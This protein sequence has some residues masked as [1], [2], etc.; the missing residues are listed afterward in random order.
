MS[1]RFADGVINAGGLCMV[2]V[3]IAAIDERVRAYLAGVL[4]GDPS[5]ELVHASVRAQRFARI[6]M[7]TADA[8]GS[9]PMALAFI[10]LASVL[11]GTFMLR[12]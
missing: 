9:E 12:G 8:H 10:A 2:V 1:S 3:G 5:S 7:D 11:V 4:S 6:V